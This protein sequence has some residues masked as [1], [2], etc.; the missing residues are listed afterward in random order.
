MYVWFNIQ[1]LVN[2]I[3]NIRRIKEKKHMIMSVDAKKAFNHIQ[4]PSMIKTQKTGLEGN[5]INIIKGLNIQKP[6]Q[7]KSKGF[8]IC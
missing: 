7:N 8:I 6:K 2:V 5:F 4:H 3:E 1:K